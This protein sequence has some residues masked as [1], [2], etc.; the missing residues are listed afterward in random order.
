MLL[1]SEAQDVIFFP[2]CCWDEFKPDIERVSRALRSLSLEHPPVDCDVIAHNKEDRRLGIVHYGK[3]IFTIDDMFFKS[4]RI[5]RIG[6]RSCR[7]FI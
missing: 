1:F 6:E 2:L 3:N 7:F 5:N 4:E